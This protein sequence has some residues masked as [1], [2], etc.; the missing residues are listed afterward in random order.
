MGEVG[1]KLF[2]TS[3]EEGTFQTKMSLVSHVMVV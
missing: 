2:T 1:E 3:L